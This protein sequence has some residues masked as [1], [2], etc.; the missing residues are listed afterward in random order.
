MNANRELVDSA[1]S[2]NSIMLAMSNIGALNEETFKD[3]QAQGVETFEQL[4]AA[5]FTEH[6]A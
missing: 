1:G 4:N 6:E 2:L 5:G 3:L